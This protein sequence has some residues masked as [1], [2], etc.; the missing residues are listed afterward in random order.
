M[1]QQA[2]DQLGSSFRLDGERKSHHLDQLK[3]SPGKTDTI[4]V[5]IGLYSGLSHHGTDGIVGQEYP[6]DL[7]D[8]A[9]W[10]FRAQDFALSPLMRFDFINHQ[11]DFPSLM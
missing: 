5:N 10:C 1:T 2:S 8:N 4:W 3:H 11:L 7:L 9:I 6:I